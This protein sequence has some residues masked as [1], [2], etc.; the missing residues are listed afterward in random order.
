VTT[1]ALPE[2]FS[3]HDNLIYGLRFEVGDPARNDWQIDL[4]FDIDHIVEWLCGSDGR[5]SFRVAPATLTFHEVTD[6]VLNIDCSD[7]TYPRTLHELS[8]DRITAAPATGPFATARPYWRYTIALNLPQGGSIN[9]GASGFSQV[10][11]A[12]PVLTTEQ[13]LAPAERAAIA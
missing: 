5:A 4:A 2:D 11:R 12:P 3:W 10:L 1:D 7:E 9:F 13:R 8:I 6:L